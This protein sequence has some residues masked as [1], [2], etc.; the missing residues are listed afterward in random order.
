M[1]QV[2]P[3][4]VCVCVC[5]YIYI[6]IYIY[7]LDYTSSALYS[8]YHENLKSVT[9]RGNSSVSSKSRR[10]LDKWQGMTEVKN[11]V[12]SVV[13]SFFQVCWMCRVLA[14]LTLITGTVVSFVA[15][16]PSK[17]QLREPQYR[18][19]F[20]HNMFFAVLWCNGSRLYDHRGN[21]GRYSPSHIP[22]YIDDEWRHCRAS[23]MV[24]EF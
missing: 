8:H 12:L 19:T 2:S 4:Y 21:W 3:K 11:S 16:D 20:C 6:Y 18:P 14:C 23:A 24:L 10:G 9:F 15:V 5:I 22:L 17:N 13:S 7:I 1:Q